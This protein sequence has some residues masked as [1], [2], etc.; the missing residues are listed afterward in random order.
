MVVDPGERVVR[1]ARAERVAALAA[2]VAEVG[3]SACAGV[4]TTARTSARILA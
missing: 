2:W 4:R 3:S 1:A